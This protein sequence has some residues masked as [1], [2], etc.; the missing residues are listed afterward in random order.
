MDR[1]RLWAAGFCVKP[2]SLLP[3]YLYA[4]LFCAN[5]GLI[6]FGFEPAHVGMECPVAALSG[7]SIIFA[8]LLI[9]FKAHVLPLRDGRSGS[10][11]RRSVL[12]YSALLALL[13][14]HVRSLLIE[15]IR[16]DGPSMKPTLMPGEGFWIRKNGG[17]EFSFPFGKS[18]IIR[19]QEFRPSRGSILVYRYPDGSCARQIW[20]KRVVAIGGDRFRFE[21]GELYINDLPESRDFSVP[22]TNL[23]PDRYQPPILQPPEEVRKLGV[24]ALYAAMNG[25]ERQGTVPQGSVLVLGDNRR[26]SRDSRVMGFVPE[27]YILGYRF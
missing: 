11:N 27:Q 18:L 21:K 1:G 25:L 17:L 13:S 6:L 2:F 15:R 14:L 10:G 5:E 4:G 26:H 19:F 24:S 9:W 23:Y 12:L 22:V 8:S 16:V 20:I 7:Y 3:I